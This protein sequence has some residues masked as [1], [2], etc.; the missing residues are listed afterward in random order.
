[1]LLNDEKGNKLIIKD[2]KRNGEEN[3]IELSVNEMTKFY[4]GTKI[5]EH[6]SFDVKSCERVGLIGQNGC[7]KSTLLKIVMGREDYQEGVIALRK[8]ATLGYLEQM[9][10]Y[11]D[12]V[13]VIDVMAGAFASLYAL[14][15]ELK[16]LEKAFLTIEGDALDKALKE[17]GR[18]IERFEQEGGYEIETKVGKVAAGLNIPEAMQQM[19]FNSLSG[20]EKTRIML[21]KILLEEPDILL[22][23]E[24][25]NHL[26]LRAIEWLEEFLKSYKGA[27]IIVS[28][29]RYFLDRTVNKI[30]EMTFDKANL[31]LGNYSYYVVEKERRFLI[32]YKFYMNQQKKIKS[33][34]EQIKRYRIWGVMRDSEKMFK[35]AKELEKRL[36]KMEKVDKPVFEKKRMHL[37]ADIATRSGK[38]VLVIEELEKQFGDLT[39]LKEVNLTVFFGDSLCILGD[40]GSGKTTLLK[41]VMNELSMDKGTITLGANTVVGYLPQIVAF[42]NEEMTLCDYF[43]DR[44]RVTTGEA[45][46]ELAKVLFV[47]EDVNKKIK[48]LSGGEKSRLKLCCLIYEKVNVMI[49]DEPTNHLDIE[50]REVLEELLMEFNGT[51]IFVSHDRYFIAK[52]GTRI[53]VIRNKTLYHYQ[54]D[55][56]Y[57]K[58][59]RQ[60]ELQREEAYENEKKALEALSHKGKLKEAELSRAEL[61]KTKDRQNALKGKNK[62]FK[63]EQLESEITRLE[64]DIALLDEE[65]LKQADNAEELNRLFMK[66]EEQ[67]ARL[68]ECYS[69]YDRL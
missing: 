68:L 27:A 19:S 12:S 3:M 51:I 21:A 30:V 53:S 26:D 66:K 41:I 4:G 31:F 49:L 24:P 67:E 65:M 43:Q 34:E 1:M 47:K 17:Y 55:Y 48:S 37:D 50:S 42:E 7:G 2:G 57:Y 63:Q 61:K 28:H 40:N 46:N 59:E 23:D 33:M 52:V 64:K 32:D 22:L 8:N 9:P 20:G 36:E 44:Y 45:R 39:L 38:R 5:F 29:D 60:K 56:E 58:E 15:H 13:Q 18:K 11:E 25:S 62:L 16:S 14:R 6:I 69:R 10:H 35:R 54:G